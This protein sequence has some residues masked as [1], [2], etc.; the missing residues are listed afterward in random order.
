VRGR[1]LNLRHDILEAN[2]NEW[3]ISFFIEK[4]NRFATEL[5]AEELSRRGGL[6]YLVRPSLLGT[7]DQRT[8]WL[9]QAWQRLPLYIRPFLL[10]FYRYILRAGFLDGKPG[11]VFHLMQSFWFR[12]LVDI[13]IEEM[14]STSERR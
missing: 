4:H 3:Q 12:L 11:F 1:T 7:P 13:R 14:Q 8:L 9:K 6:P 10:F 2:E 5:A